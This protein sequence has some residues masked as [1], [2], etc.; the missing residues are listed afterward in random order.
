[1]KTR[2][3]IAC[4]V[5]VFLVQTHHLWAQKGIESLACPSEIQLA[6]QDMELTTFVH[7]GPAT[8]QDQEYDDLKTPL[9]RI[10]PVLLD[11]DQWAKVARS[12]GSKMIIMVAKHTGGF[13][14]WPTSTTDYNIS[15]TPWRNG[16]GDLMKSLS[17]SCKKYG[18]KFGV[19]LSPEDQ[20]LKVGMGGTAR[21]PNFQAQYEKIYRKQLTELLT[22]YG[23]ISELWVDGS[24]VFDVSDL[25]A[26]YAP[27][28]VVLQSSAASVRW[29]GNEMGFAPYPAWNSV[30]KEDARSG[31]TTASNGTPWGNT[32]LPLEVDV[33]IRR[34]NW[35]WR[36]NNEDRV[37]TLEELL[38]IYYASVGRGTVFLT[39][40][41]PDTLGRI[42]A[43]DSAVLEALGKELQERFGK[44]LAETKGEGKTLLLDLKSQKPID[45][46]VL[47]EDIRFG[48]RIHQFVLEGKQGDHWISLF[49]G[50]SIGHKLIVQLPSALKLSQIRL[51]VTDAVGTPKIRSMKAFFVDKP[52]IVIPEPQ[53]N[54]NIK[55]I[56]TWAAEELLS[57]VLETELELSTYCKDARQYELA[58]VVV[59]EG[60]TSVKF[61]YDWQNTGL[62]LDNLAEEKR[63]T[64]TDV[65]LLF[66][67][68]NA[69]HYLYDN[70]KF[71][72]RI[73]FNLTGIPTSLKIQTK[74]KGLGGLKNQRIEAYLLRK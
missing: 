6:W 72:D 56:G 11:T 37:L 5:L 40:L 27:R 71:K 47:M 35:F 53:D 10:N 49:D 25:I 23:E 42:P 21:D 61:S 24:L 17:E 15:R 48:E 45:H 70:K 26:R 33:S 68:A 74:V 52:T 12:Y 39:N 2:K 60:G 18:L 22:S 16:K 66:A 51:R 69:N 50:I 64:V 67:G 36:T 57:D 59:P 3:I 28:A 9:S 43:K 19:Y 44:S 41:C 29:V 20:Y 13:C 63:L 32:W 4:F 1:M 46:V 34:P 30:S 31:N 54:W 14:W 62:W 8:W 55:H 58:F 73:Q 7:F 38:Q 65:Q